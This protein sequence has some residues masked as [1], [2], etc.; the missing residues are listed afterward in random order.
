[1]PFSHF[2]Q[3]LSLPGGADGAYVQLPSRALTGVDTLSVVGWLKV[4]DLTPW[5]RFF[6]LGQ[7]MARH[8]FCTPVGEERADGCR[9]RITVRG[10]TEEQ[11]PAT[12]RA[13]VS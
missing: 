4:K 8:F 13:R 2:G 9:A 1:M 11:G 7:D 6:D 3:V 10:W 12:F 5:Q